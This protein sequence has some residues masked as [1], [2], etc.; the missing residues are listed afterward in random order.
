MEPPDGLP[1][2][3]RYI[4]VLGIVLSIAMTVL[5]SSMVNVALPSIARDLGVQPATATWIINAYQ[6][7]I[8]ATLL[9]FASL[10]E[11]LGYRRVYVAG[12]VVFLFAT[13]ACALAPNFP[14]LLAFRI[15]E[16][17]ACSATMS[18]TTGLTR[19]TYPQKQLGRAIGITAMVV[20]VSGATGPSIA[21]AVLAVLPWP[22]LF[23]VSIPVGIVSLLCAAAAPEVPRAHRSF[24]VLSALLCAASFGLL[25]LGA[26]LLAIQPAAG[27]ACLGGALAAGFALVQ[28]QVSQPAPLLPLDLLRIRVV[29]LSVVAS[30]CLFS[31]WGM[32]FVSMPF[33]LQAAG[34]GQVET[35]LLITPWPVALAFAAPLAGRLS[36][37]VPTGLLCGC[38][39][40][41]LATGVAGIVLLG[42]DAPAPLL[43]VLM[44][45]CGA[46]F[47]FFQTPN[48]R[49][50]LGAAPRARSGSAGGMQSTA[51][52][53]GQ[54][55]GTTLTALTF[56][57]APSAG[58][59]TALLIGAGAA[60]LGA[61]ISMLR[62]RTT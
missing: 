58:P 14:T 56:T 36:D 45:L 39:G 35:G 48:N 5:D 62:H 20:A 26:D 42:G 25:F 24:D 13:T 23:V 51:R 11:V 50:M 41:A 40:V 55:T 44:A 6:L 10:G 32:V 1:T 43:A 18:L 33:L 8:V 54:T 34:R 21:A 29:A 61:A 30:V 59:S 22:Y 12:I 4:A 3:R 49:T 7:T 9:S 27:L 28:R 15:I 2:P 31:A 52:L 37:R 46:G 17:L 16:G 60:L 57:L 47:G 19:F 53:T 38:G